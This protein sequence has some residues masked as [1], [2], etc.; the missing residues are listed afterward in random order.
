MLANRMPSTAMP[1][2]KS[3]ATMRSSAETGRPGSSPSAAGSVNPVFAAAETFMTGPPRG[4][5]YA[6]SAVGHKAVL[7]RLAQRAARGFG[8]GAVRE[9]AGLELRHPTRWNE[10]P[11][12]SCQFGAA[13]ELIP[14]PLGIAGYGERAELDPPAAAACGRGR[15]H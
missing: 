13:A 11:R 5:S 9:A 12:P 14:Q 3:S 7:A 1:R 6:R 10:Q 15:R 4:R 8:R 2:M